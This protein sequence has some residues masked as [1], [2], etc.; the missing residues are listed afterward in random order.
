MGQNAPAR[1]QDLAIPLAVTGNAF[2]DGT[3][4]PRA[5]FEITLPMRWQIDV[6]RPVQ[7]AP[8]FRRVKGVSC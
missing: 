7:M 4:P 3:M 6:F 2:D 1:E 8:G 5:T